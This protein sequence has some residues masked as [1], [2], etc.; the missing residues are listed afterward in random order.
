MKS[1]GGL[2]WVRLVVYFGIGYYFWEIYIDF[3]ENA[4]R[5]REIFYP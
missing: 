2:A 4:G 3:N 5:K 1:P